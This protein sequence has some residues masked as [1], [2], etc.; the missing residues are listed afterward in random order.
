MAPRPNWKGYLKLSLVSCPVALYPATSSTERVSFRQVNRQ[1]GHRLRQQLI[2]E[3][4]REPVEA[5]EKGR[6]YEIG[7]GQF[8]MVE[9]EELDA[10]EIESSHTIDIDRFVP[11]SQIDK[12]YFDVPY[13]IV[14][15]DTVGQ[16]AFAVIRDAMKGKGMVALGR[17]VMSKRERVIALEPEGKGLLG[18]TLRYAYEVRDSATYFDD[19]P[20]L[21]VPTEML[22]LAEHIL[23]TKAGDFDPSQFEDH[24]ENALV[25]LLKR[26][27]AGVAP[28][29]PKAAP[30]ASN[31]V[32][33]MDAL[34]R[35][36]AQHTAAPRPA[37][38]PKTKVPSKKTAARKQEEAR[39]APQF[40]LPIPGGKK[41]GAETKPAAKRQ[42][43]PEPKTASRK[44]AG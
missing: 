28:A 21:K 14:P 29:A 3:V 34:K 32:N 11:A 41:Q 20:D 15:N 8:L 17:V 26:K 27:Q 44:R 2:D 38:T 35:S 30:A 37:P 16:D 42:P 5:A 24:Y 1:T 13:Y 43:K 6:G 7:K 4:T 12:R 10:I 25:D 19:I 39:R 22:K 36:L 9:D 33:L 23:D 31:V 18:M 40:K